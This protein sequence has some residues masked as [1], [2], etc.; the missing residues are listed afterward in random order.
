[1]HLDGYYVSFYWAEFPVEYLETVRFKS[2]NEL[3]SMDKIVIRHTKPMSLVDPDERDQFLQE[4]LSIIR[5]LVDG[6]GRIGFLRHD[7]D[8]NPIHR[9]SNAP[10]PQSDEE[11]ELAQSDQEVELTTTLKA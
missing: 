5:C 9:D 4:F 11:S 6:K 3:Q 2:L 7:M 10:D 1:M 8:P